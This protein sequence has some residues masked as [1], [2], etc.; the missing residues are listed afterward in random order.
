MIS[1]LSTLHNS[2]QNN[3]TTSTYHYNIYYEYFKIYFYFNDNY[4]QQDFF[5]FIQMFSFFVFC[6]AYMIQ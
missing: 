2:K 5:P 1:K 3:T 6:F 4:T